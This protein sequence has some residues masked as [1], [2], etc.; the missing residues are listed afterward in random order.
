[1]EGIFL[2]LNQ[3]TYGREEIISWWGN[4][5]LMELSLLL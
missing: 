2:T 3:Y 1:M 4:L 5:I